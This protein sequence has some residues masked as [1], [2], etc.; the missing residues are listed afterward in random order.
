MT[1]HGNPDTEQLLRAYFGD[2]DAAL[3]DLPRARREQLIGEIRQHVDQ[4]LAE[5]QPGSTSDVRDVLGR[6][7]QPEEIAAAA[8]DEE[9]GARPRR[10]GT[11][12][13]LLIAGA[14]LL[15]V[16][17]L[18]IGLVLG[19][20]SPTNPSAGR[21]TTTSSRSHHSTTTLPTSPPQST[22][23]SPTT[24]TSSPPISTTAPLRAVLSPATVP[25]VGDECTVELTFDADGNVAPL[26]CPD[27]GVN[28][29]A[30]QHYAQG[31]VNGQPSTWSKVLQLGPYASPSQVYQA[32]CTDY[33][34]VY[35][36]KPLTV[37][38]EQ[39]AA[40]YYGWQFAGDNPELDFQQ[41][42]CP[43]PS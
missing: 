6:V 27:G 31:S 10:M 24:T 1:V 23:T 25:P 21:T 22:T 33:Q 7:G 32:M 19:L 14:A 39:L 37:S 5:L 26:L 13:R 20:S 18:V 36:T 40:A 17:G 15:A 41:L 30:W 43:P 12:V 9:A 34:D 2:L 35:G 42:G 4:A 16:A 8:L 11:R 29:L 38:A 28:A 3:S